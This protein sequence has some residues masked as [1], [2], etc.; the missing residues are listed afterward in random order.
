MP[1]RHD[2]G[3]ARALGAPLLFSLLAVVLFAPAL[4]GSSDLSLG[5]SLWFDLPRDLVVARSA[6]SGTF[7]TWL[8]GI[9]GGASA[10]GAQEFALFYP[11]NTLLAVLFPDR[12]RALGLALHMV[13]AALGARALAKRLGIGDAAALFAGVAFGFG[14]AVVS[15]TFVPVYVRSAAWLPFCVLGVIRGAAGDRRGLLIA[16]SAFLMTYLGGDPIGCVFAA[17]AAMVTALAAREIP[18]RRALVRGAGVVALSAGAVAL[19]GAVQLVPAVLA[20]RESVR[21][22][23]YTFYG[24][25][26]WSLWPPELAGMAVPYLFG[27]HAHLETSWI[28]SVTPD[29][30]RLWNETD[31][32]GPLV[33]AFA[34]VGALRG[35]TRPGGRAGLALFALF[36]LLAFGRSS[37][38]YW[39]VYHVVPPFDI[40]RY[41]AKLLIPATLGLALLGAQG[42]DALLGGDERGRRIA[43]AL[44]GL[45]GGLSLVASNWVTLE[46]ESLGATI[47]A[48]GVEGTAGKAAVES[49]GARLAHAAFVA[50]GGGALLAGRRWRSPRLGAACVAL[51]SVDLALGLRAGIGFQPA[52]DLQRPPFAAAA[53]EREAARTGMPARVYPTREEIV[54]GLGASPRRAI[55]ALMPNCGLADGVLSQS[56][57]LS[58][59]PLR[60]SVLATQALFLAQERALGPS[61]LVALQGARYALAAGPTAEAFAAEGARPVAALDDLVLFEVDAAPPWAALYTRVRFVPDIQRGLE[62]IRARDF[63]PRREVALEAP[64][65]PVAEGA[66]GDGGAVRLASGFAPGR[67]ELAVEARVPSWLV[68]REAFA[69][70]WSA[71]VDGRETPIVPADV[72]FRAV[73]V[74]AGASR[75]LFTF[76]SGVALGACVSVLSLI[77]LG[78]VVLVRSARFAS[79]KKAPGAP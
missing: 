75:V 9:Y 28:R 8:P 72:G 7:P 12:A 5:D 25:T 26:I 10:V 68:V 47:E 66:A 58:S 63:D 39:L 4:L 32:A 48:L 42:L 78:I 59:P 33:L 43:L 69:R 37:P 71:R 64:A 46:A 51:L 53:L 1:G 36:L 11:P 18:A 14:G 49:L 74:P 6:R 56:G 2:E 60:A 38:L 31:Y 13:I 40:F 50:I 79:G 41:P 24:A 65:E 57:F 52:D 67:F 70:G 34:L 61:R 35:R 54:R 77:A 22:E 16:G 19:V 3:R 55:D 17:T 23:G 30:D 76:D 21:G 44:L 62:T 29:H 73:K 20:T 15:M 45:L 27:M